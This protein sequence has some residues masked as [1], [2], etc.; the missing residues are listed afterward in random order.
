M[1]NKRI[2]DIQKISRELLEHITRENLIEKF[3]TLQD[4]YYSAIKTLENVIDNLN[5]IRNEN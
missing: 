1:H 2:T 3:L 4:M 5:K